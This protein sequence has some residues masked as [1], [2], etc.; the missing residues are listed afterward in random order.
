MNLSACAALLSGAVQAAEPIRVLLV[1][2]QNNHSWEETTPLMVEALNE[3][4][5][6]QVDVATEI[7]TFNA[8]KLEPYDVILSNWNLWKHRRNGVPPELAWPEE[9]RKAYVDFVRNGKGHV[10]IHAGSSS[11]Y[12]W[13]EYQEICVATW[14]LGQTGHGPAHEFDVR[15]D[16]PEHPIMQGLGTF[17]KWDELWQRVDAHPDA[18]LLASSYCAKEYKGDDN[19]E[20][21]T[22]VKTFGKGRTAYN[23]FGHSR[24]SYESPE[25]RV[26]L[27][28]LV[29][30][31]ATGHVTIPYPLIAQ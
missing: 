2:G 26:L 13:P 23:S 6:F 30:W 9:L 8:A 24:K 14:K 1:T 16:A 31:A 19:W 11:F 12:D 20:P 28:R 27:A 5:R 7:Q 18:K 22:F 3:T 21:N 4:G 17:R 29:E 10:A 15:I 25:F